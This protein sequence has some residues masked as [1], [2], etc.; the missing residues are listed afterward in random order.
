MKQKT[1]L[2]FG[3]LILAA[4]AAF[5]FSDLPGSQDDSNGGGGLGTQLED[6]ESSG[7]GAQAPSSTSPVGFT[8]ERSWR[9]HFEKHGTEF[10]SIDADEYLE[11]AKALR[12]AP[13]SDD[14]LEIRR[15][16]GVVTRFDRRTGAFVAFHADKSIRTFF[17]PNDG[18]NYFRRQADR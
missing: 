16:D 9:S 8:S 17:R 18:E 13:L 10:G 12:D 15:R 2:S 14:V 1:G 4:I 3:G 7:D 11:R 6:R 5:F